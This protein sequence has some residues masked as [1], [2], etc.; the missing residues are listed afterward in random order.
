MTRQIFA[1]KVVGMT[2]TWTHYKIQS[3][4]NPSLG[5]ICYASYEHMVGESGVR[6]DTHSTNIFLVENAP[7]LDPAPEWYLRRKFSD[8]VHARV[9]KVEIMADM[10]LNGEE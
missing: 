7:E 6:C 2:H 3:K 5:Q 4:R 9:G 1:T 10:K 8:A